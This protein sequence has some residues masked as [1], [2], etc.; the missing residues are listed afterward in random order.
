[1]KGHLNKPIKTSEQLKLLSDEQIENIVKELQLAIHIKP[2]LKKYI[3]LETGSR[4][5]KQDFEQFLVN[6]GYT[7]FI[8]NVWIHTKEQS[9]TLEQTINIEPESIGPYTTYRNI[10]ESYKVLPFGECLI[11][12]NE[13][14]DINGTKYM[15][16]IHPADVLIPIKDMENLEQEVKDK[17]DIEIVLALDTTG[18]M[19][20]YRDKIRNNFSTIITEV[21]SKYNNVKLSIIQFGDYIDYPNHI[22]IG[23]LTN[24]LVEL[25]EQLK[26][27]DT[28][29]GDNEEFYEFV[30][31]QINENKVQFSKN[32]KKVVVLLFDNDYHKFDYRVEY[33]SEITS[34]RNCKFDIKKELETL[35][36]NNISLYGITVH[37]GG[38]LNCPKTISEIFNTPKLDFSENPN[39]I[40]ELITGI[41]LKNVDIQQLENYTNKQTDLTLTTLLKKL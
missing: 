18:S 21:L 29:G 34:N 33:S 15:K 2:I 12:R 13:P 36:N 7:K 40:T 3:K 19:N 30:L 20:E 28:E 1:M 35:K 37:Y 9:K 26:S 14:I 11:I 31:N 5:D 17:Q 39:C 4:I 24:N 23:R 6:K 32:S 27:F 22:K 10:N 25:N 16:V 41:I 38:H 8:N